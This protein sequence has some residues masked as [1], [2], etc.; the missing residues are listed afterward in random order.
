MLYLEK[1]VKTSEHIQEGV[2]FREHKQDAV[3]NL[4]QSYKVMQNY[5]NS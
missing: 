1:L 2:N 5:T 3:P 4:Y